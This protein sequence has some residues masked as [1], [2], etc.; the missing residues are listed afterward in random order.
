MIKY[1][2]SL[3]I[4]LLAATMLCAETPVLEKLRSIAAVSDIREIKVRES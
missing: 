3:L 1:F 2:L 4:A